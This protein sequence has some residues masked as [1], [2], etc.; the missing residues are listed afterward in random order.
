[1]SEHL[2]FHEVEVGGRLV[3]VVLRDGRVAA[4]RNPTPT[5]GAAAIDGRGGALLPGLHDHHLH[6]LATAAAEHSV[7]CASAKDGASLAAALQA[8][9]PGWVRAVGYHEQIAGVLDRGVLDQLAPNHP[10]RVQHRTG[11]LWMLNS[12]ALALVDHLLDGSPD[13]ERDESGRP[14]G[15]LWRYDARLRP[16]FASGPPSLAALGARLASFGITGVTDA[17]PDL[18]RT[19]LDLLARAHA[20]GDLPQEITLLGAPEARGLASGLRRGPRKIHLRDHDLPTLP[21]LAATVAQTH[22]GDRGVAIH[23]VTAEALVLAVA[24]LLD[25]GIHP[26]DRIEHASV[27]PPGAATELAELGVAVVTQPAFLHERGDD[28]LRDVASPERDWLYP[29]RSLLEAG[30]PVA[31][32]SDAPHAPPDPWLAIA[33]AAGRRTRRGAVI[34][35]GEAVDA[36][37]VLD[38]FL[39]SPD[40]PGGPPRRVA[41]GLPAD[42]C[43]LD[44]PLADALAGVPANPVRMTLI[45][46]RIVHG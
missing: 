22:R 2:V 35:A 17:T 28:Y 24:A 44:R 7:D 6:L 11:A 34:G 25:A 41:P 1:L 42:L 46:G 9:G 8:A 43:L 10:V 12:R 27:V 26:T 15:R 36:S 39:S 32:S 45:G 18:D 4:V 40:N 13:V 33:A 3:N 38:G 16:A 5:A 21:E 30:V 29:Y 14:T 20:S 23:C 37:R 31:P 19:S